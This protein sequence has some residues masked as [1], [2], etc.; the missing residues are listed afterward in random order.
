MAM[1]NKALV[2]V[3]SLGAILL[4]VFGILYAI[5][6]SS[7]PERVFY[8]M[9]QNNLSIGSVSRTVSQESNDQSLLQVTQT[10]T[11]DKNIVQGRTVL[12]Q[13]TGTSGTSVVTESIAT[14]GNDYIRYVDVDT[15]ETG[16][17]GE[18]L[19]FGSVLGVWGRS[20]LDAPGERNGELF[21]ESTLGIVPFGQLD[22]E[23]REEFVAYIKE[24]G[25]YTI[26]F[27]TVSEKMVDGRK[28][29]VYQAQ[30]SPEKYV[31]MLQRFASY[32]GTSQLESLEAENFKDSP[33]I[34]ITFEVDVWSRQLRQATF[35]DSD[36]SESYESYGL[37]SEVAIP[38]DTVPVNQLQQ[39][40]Q[41]IQ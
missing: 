29:Y 6:K 3:F 10:Q 18:P 37:Y 7:T 40:L 17:S 13:G 19:N 20:E 1:T 25:V 2:V 14:P 11:G 27:S 24:L 16:I 31:L 35:T 33:S 41:A 5:D 26:D 34:N 30:I 36:R 21:G 9:I 4:T 39:L 15:A 22:D 23:S 28:S 32:I 8:K 12:S 38:E